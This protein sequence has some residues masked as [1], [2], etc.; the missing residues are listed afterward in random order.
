MLIQLPSFLRL[1]LLSVLVLLAAGCA[2]VDHKVGPRPLPSTVVY[3]VRHAEKEATPGL[4][5]P[6]LTAAGQQRAQI[7]ADT[8]RK[9]P[10]TAAFST[11]TTRTRSTAAPLAAA[12]SLTVQPYEAGQLAALATRIRREY[13]G[14]AVLVVGHSNTILETVE[15][16]G[17][18][19]PVSAV[20]DS[21]YD[22]LL[23]VRLPADTTQAATVVARRYGAAS[24]R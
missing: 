8:L 17:A 2:S 22:Y 16:L 11:A 10:I 20:Q 3:V 24:G 9:A 19:R 21:E 7:L 23:E 5:D 15:A 4:Q 13:R 18:K 1:W 6:P 12:R 14:K